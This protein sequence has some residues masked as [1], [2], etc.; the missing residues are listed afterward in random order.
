M[1]KTFIRLSKEYVTT[2]PNRRMQILESKTIQKNLDYFNWFTD[3]LRGDLYE[4][5]EDN[6]YYNEWIKVKNLYESLKVKAKNIV[7]GKLVDVVV[8]KNYDEDRVEAAI[9]RDRFIVNKQDLIK[10]K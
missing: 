2:Y 9:G 5:P 4:L 6:V 1:N 3:M 10:L 7:C 8:L